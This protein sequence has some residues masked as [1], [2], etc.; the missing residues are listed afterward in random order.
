MASSFAAFY[1]AKSGIQ[2]ANYN[3]KVTGQNISNVNTDGYTRQRLDAYAVGSS[4]N[5]MRYANKNDLAIGE[6]VNCAGVS[7]LRD[8]YLDVRYRLE[9]A[10]V[11]QTGT[12]LSTLND[13]ESVFDEVKTDGINTQ[14]TDL[15]KQLSTLAGSPSDTS[16]ENIVKN[17]SLLLTKAF[18]N[19]AQQLTEV[20]NQQTN[21]FKSDAIST[22]NTL[23]QNIAHV[24]DEIKSS[25]VSGTPALELRDQRNSMLDEL[26]QY[27][28]IQ[29]STKSVPIGANRTVDELSVNLVS[30]DGSKVNLVDSGK[31]NQFD[32]KLDS[33][34]KQYKTDAG[35]LYATK[36]LHAAIFLTDSNGTENTDSSGNSL[37][38]NDDV[39]SGVFGGYL[40]MLNDEGEF[41]AVLPKTVGTPPNT[42][43]SP[44]L[45]STTRGIG[46][47]EKALDKFAA[48]FANIMN[49]ANSTNKT[50]DPNK[51]LF[52][53]SDGSTSGITADNI[54]ISKQGDTSGGSYMTATKDETLPGVV[55]S[56]A[57][58]NI[59]YM[60]SLFSNKKTYTTASDNSGDGT[61]LF[62]T[63][64]NS[65][66]SDISTTLG[67][68]INTTGKQNDT[69]TSNITDVDTQRSAI[70]SIDV[71]EEGINLIMFNQALTASSRFM[72]TMD[73]A[74]DTI[75][76]KM[77]VVGR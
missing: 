17:S 30:A 37:L 66:I 9:H 31:Y 21:S 32:V 75:I 53:T 2:A 11:G 7:Q 18:N 27:V 36:D 19:A 71:N 58:K 12:E 24:N 56:K 13:L 52:T 67:L 40:S 70:S 76:N 54:S 22:V 5:N 69:Y 14:L 72:T 62:T 74:L 39:T 68:Q 49:T 63:S 45:P 33:V 10:K 4:G 57:G 48:E 20:R 1:V 16:L 8:P 38:T 73:E 61:T 25:D 50:G 35:N 42:E 34:S 64:L 29:I 51:P 55:N 44:A 47:Y 3:L 41:D 23:L 65:F 77:G 46:Y 59:L 15:V 26:S 28:N 60:V 6:G 43:T